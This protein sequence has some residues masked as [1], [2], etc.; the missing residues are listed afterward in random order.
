MA[1]VITFSTVFP[2]GHPKQGLKTLFVEKIHSSF[3]EKDET[4]T[5]VDRDLIE[6]FNFAHYRDCNPKHHTIRAG[7]RWK[8]GDKFSPRIWSGKP[9]NSPMIRIGNDT[10][11]KKIF[12]IEIYETSEVMINGKFF[13][14]FGSEKWH[15]LAKNDGL[16]SEDM[17]NWFSKLPFKG[18][19]ICWNENINY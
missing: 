17:R 12:N 1:K 13:C 15:E 4:K 5:F 6:H 7:K 19:I 14:S 18:Q 8:Q 2:K 11:I 3:D 9:Y 10:E 16:S